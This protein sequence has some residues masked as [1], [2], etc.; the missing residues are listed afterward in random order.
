MSTA[1]TP[2]Q[3]YLSI[4]AAAEYLGVGVTTLYRRISDGSLPAYD[5]GAP[6]AGKRTIRI[7]REDL[8]ALL[9]P[10][11]SGVVR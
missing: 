2:G 8:D 5:I 4:P 1:S 11:P 3:A 10:L 7:A 6:D 9:R